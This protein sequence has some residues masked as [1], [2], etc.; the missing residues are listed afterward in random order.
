MTKARL[1]QRALLFLEPRQKIILLHLHSFDKLQIVLFLKLISFNKKVN[2]HSK[3][4]P[5][6]NCKDVNTAIKA[7]VDS[8]VH[9]MKNY[10]TC[11]ICY[12]NTRNPHNHIHERFSL[13]SPKIIPA[14]FSQKITSF[15]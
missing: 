15:L 2:N 9:E 6:H 7:T 10:A 3:E 13:S 1:L 12:Y 11:Y 14:I 8:F 4:T 5:R